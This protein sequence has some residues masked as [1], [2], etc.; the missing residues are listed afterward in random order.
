MPLRSWVPPGPSPMPDEDLSLNPVPVSGESESLPCHL[1]RVTTPTPTSAPDLDPW[2]GPK[3]RA[4][5]SWPSSRT[6]PSPPQSCPLVPTPAPTPP[7]GGL[8]DPAPK[9][10]SPS[11][12]SA[13]FCPFHN[14][15]SSPPSSSSES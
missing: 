13:S 3:R 2:V 7:P 10:N 1:R 15:L 9:I 12:F 11:N 4:S 14:P 5:T 6:V 8:S